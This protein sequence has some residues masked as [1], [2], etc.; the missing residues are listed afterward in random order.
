MRTQKKRKWTAEEVARW[1]QQTG[2]ITYANP[3]DANWVV[4]KPRSLGWTLN[5]A[6]PKS[7]LIAAGILIALWAAVKAF[8]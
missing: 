2:A 7:C 3:E 6:N 5:W 4:R 1:Y 8:L